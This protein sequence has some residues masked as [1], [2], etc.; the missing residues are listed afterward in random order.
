MRFFLLAALSCLSPLAYADAS[1]YQPQLALINEGHP[2]EAYTQLRPKLL[3]SAGNPDYDTAFGLA[4]LDSGATAEAVAA[5]ER[6]LATEPDNLPVRT[7]LARAYQQLGDP[8]AAA[9]ELQTVAAQPQTPTNVRANISHYAS[10]LDE[11]L[12]GGP[13]TFTGTVNVSTGYNSNLNN[14]TTSSYLVVPALA[15][16]GPARIEDGARSASGAY[17]QTDA[18]LTYRKPLSLSRALFASVN[19]EQLSPLNSSDYQQTTVGAEAGVQFLT[20]D[21]G[22]F[23]VGA[24]AQQFWFGGDDYST[25]IGLAANWQLALGNTSTLTTYATVSHINYAEDSMPD[26]N[27]FV[28]GTTLANR[29]QTALAPY[30]FAGL[31]GGTE[32]T[33][34]SNANV[35]TYNLVGL[36]TGVEVFPLP[37]L[38]TFLD[39]SYEI[40]DYDADYPLFMNA[41]LDRQLDLTTGVAYALTPQWSLRPTVAYRY[42]GSNIAFYNYTRWLASLGARYT[43]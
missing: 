20:P 30:A 33:N 18:T 13:A 23:T 25:S 28:L 24:N 27:R 16:L 43:F 12:S 36:Q 19:A 3:G 15:A 6:V 14:A 31:Y 39:A 2:S 21:D 11:A 17:A 35:F 38:S 29:W 37:N 4:A 41:R 1:P 32:K 26:A 8:A 34:G 40:R 7:E 22:T 42:A 5:L 10:T 9:R